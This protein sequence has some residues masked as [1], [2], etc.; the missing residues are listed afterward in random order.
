MARIP[1]PRPSSPTSHPPLSS[2]LPGAAGVTGALPLVVALAGLGLSLSPPSMDPGWPILGALALGAGA[3]WLG[4]DA[5]S[6]R[7]DP[8]AR[9]RVSQLER[10]LLSLTWLGRHD[11][12]ARLPDGPE[13]GAQGKPDGAPPRKR[14]RVRG[15]LLRGAA[16]G[17][18][19]ALDDP[20]PGEPA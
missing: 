9:A 6:A 18:G 10:A 7:P 16:T 14:G 20:L 3:Y 8:G 5:G 11:G 13:P 17:P 1:T 19:P 12:E 15:P 2:R 4:R